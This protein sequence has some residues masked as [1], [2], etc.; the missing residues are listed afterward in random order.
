[1]TK[2]INI[3]ERSA[4]ESLSEDGH[5]LNNSRLE[6]ASQKS[7]Y[8]L[9]SFAFESNLKKFDIRETQMHKMPLQYNERNLVKRI[10]MPN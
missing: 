8:G 9:E 7:R 6:V 10:D 5:M 3:E 2:H 4:E 1:M